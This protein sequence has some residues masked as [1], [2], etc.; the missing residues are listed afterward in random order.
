MKKL[1]KNTKILNFNWLRK[2]L[3]WIVVLTPNVYKL[4]STIHILNFTYIKLCSNDAEGRI[5]T[6]YYKVSL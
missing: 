5:F 2:T 3:L 4:R 1:R 6:H